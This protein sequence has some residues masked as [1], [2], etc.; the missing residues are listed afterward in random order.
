MNDVTKW[1]CGYTSPD[2]EDITLHE[3]LYPYAAK[4]LMDWLEHHGVAEGTLGLDPE[5]C[6]DAV[7]TIAHS[8][9]AETAHDFII[10]EYVF[11]L[12]TA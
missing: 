11:W 8:L 2:D 6:G 9:P 4:V 7:A 1:T 3:G 10:G 5:L 12:C